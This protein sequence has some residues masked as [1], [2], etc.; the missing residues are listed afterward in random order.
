MP[1]NPWVLLAIVLAF[2]GVA[3]GAYIKGGRDAVNAELAATAREEK[4][5]AAVELRAQK[6][7]AEAIA[8]NRPINKTIHNAIEKETIRDTQYRDCHHSPDTFRLLN[9]KLQNGY[10]GTESARDLELPKVLPGPPG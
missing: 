8:K 6:G 5:V 9:D 7:A 1:L 2:L 10:F 3:T 4:L